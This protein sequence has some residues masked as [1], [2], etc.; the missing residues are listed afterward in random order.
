MKPTPEATF[1]M[2]AM[3]DV[4]LLLVIFFVISAQ[5]AQAVRKPLNLPDQPGEAGSRTRPDAVIVDIEAGG[6]MFSAGE[7]LDME[8]LRATLRSSIAQAGNDP[9][10]VE[11]IVRCDAGAPAA[12]LNRAARLFSEMGL[13]SWRLATKGQGSTRGAPGEGVGG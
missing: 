8:G 4:V 12:H 9:E 11:V 6:G 1:D 10:G 2:T 13:R 5:F 7:R 3:S